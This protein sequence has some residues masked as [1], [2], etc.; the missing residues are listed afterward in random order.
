MDKSS[1]RKRSC[2]VAPKETQ[3]KISMARL[4]R[5][6]CIKYLYNK[7]YNSDFITT[8]HTTVIYMMMMEV[9][10]VWSELLVNLPTSPRNNITTIGA[11][12]NIAVTIKNG[13]AISSIKHS[14]SK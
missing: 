8:S 9:K 14:N 6:G 2:A 12:A 1:E 4:V 11:S 5:V 3:E 10:R 7:I 13:W